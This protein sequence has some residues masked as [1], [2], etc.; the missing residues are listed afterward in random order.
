[1]T[2]VEERLQ[3]LE[4]KEAIRDMLLEY[5]RALDSRDTQAYADLFAADGEW[6]GGIGS[7]RTPAGIK[8][9]LDDLFAGAPPVDP[10][11][12]PRP[13]PH[14]L[15][16]NMVVNVTGDI[17]TAH[18]RWAWVRAGADGA[19]HMLRSGF[20]EDEFVRENG[21]WKIRKRRA[22]TELDQVGSR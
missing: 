20:Y 1:M 9:M 8:K 12:S 13:K 6:S 15:M 19:P 5:G 14:H 18:S 21:A 10:A 17:A 22:V 7:S 3:I 11:A 2:S 16:S 4:D